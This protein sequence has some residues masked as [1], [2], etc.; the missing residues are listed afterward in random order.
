M[1]QILSQRKLGNFQKL[2]ASNRNSQCREGNFLV[3]ETD[4][5]MKCL[6]DF[7]SNAVW[8]VIQLKWKTFASKQIG[9]FTH[10]HLKKKREKRISYRAGK[11]FC[12]LIKFLKQKIYSPLK[13]CPK[14]Q[15]SFATI[16]CK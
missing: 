15:T 11:T 6:A 14:N 13:G 10:F 1:K 7:P 16:L 5:D 12:P 8:S 3:K 2:H 4:V 9:D